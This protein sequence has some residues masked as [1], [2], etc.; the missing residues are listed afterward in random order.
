MKKLIFIFTLISGFVF[1]QSCTGPEGPRGPQ[2]FPGPASEVFEITGSFTANNDFSIGVD[3]SPAIFVEDVILVYELSG[4]FSGNDI[5]SPLPKTYY[6]N[7]GRDLRYHFDFSRHDVQIYLDVIDP[8][9]VPNQY[10]LSKTFRIVIVPGYF[11]L[12]G[13]D[14]NDIDAVM[15]VLNLNNDSVIEL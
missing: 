7:D 8:W 2:G 13:I 11:S 1:L 6:L 9:N 10:V 5:W 3:L 12:D 14:L 15:N 4:S